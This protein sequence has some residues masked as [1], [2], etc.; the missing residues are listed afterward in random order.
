[1]LAG[2]QG[3]LVLRVVH[4]TEIQKGLREA[5]PPEMAVVLY[6]R[7]M[8][9]I[10]S[11]AARA[12]RALAL[13]T[14]DNL[15]QVASQ[16]LENLSTIEEAATLPVLRPLLTYDKSETT[17]LA[18]RIGTFDLSALPY[19]DCCSL[20]VPEHP[21][22]RARVEVAAAVEARLPIAD[23]TQ[24]AAETAEIFELG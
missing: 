8:I 6:R 4:F 1:M 10:A 15:G 23:W 16:T 11:H 7:M 20:F 13:A 18:Q 24:K 12:G 5:G 9:R 21:E 22:L 14:G 3:G 17:A 19:E 2:W